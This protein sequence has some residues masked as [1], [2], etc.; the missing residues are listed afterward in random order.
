MLGFVNRFILQ[1]FFIRLFVAVAEGTPQ[2]WGVLYWI[3]PTTGWNSKYKSL[4]KVKYFYF[5]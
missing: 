4:G 3:V 2:Y 1:W 5:N